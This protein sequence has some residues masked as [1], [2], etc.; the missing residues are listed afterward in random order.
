MAS[1]RGAGGRKGKTMSSQEKVSHRPANELRTKRNKERH[2]AQQ[3]A[4]KARSRAL[5]A[6]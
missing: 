6:A 3:A 2:L 4:K 1:N 5:A